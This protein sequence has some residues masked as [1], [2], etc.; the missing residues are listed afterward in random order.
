MLVASAAA[1]HSGWSAVQRGTQLPQVCHRSPAPALWGSRQMPGII[2]PG[3]LW[4]ILQILPSSAACCNKTQKPRL[5]PLSPIC[6]WLTE[7][8]SS[9]DVGVLSLGPKRPWKSLSHAEISATTRLGAQASLLQELAGQGA[10]GQP[11]LRV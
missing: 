5:H 4:Q 6:P 9:D 8:S 3:S 7:H 10:Q 2:H 1:A 11:A